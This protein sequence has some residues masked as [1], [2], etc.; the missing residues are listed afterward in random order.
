MVCS[1]SGG[2]NEDPCSSE[3]TG[4][5]DKF[6]ITEEHE[7]NHIKIMSAVPKKMGG[8]INS[9]NACSMGNKEK[10]EAIVKLENFDTERRGITECCSGSL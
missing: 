5:I 2:K 6:E 8:E 1:V 10:M 7:K 3:A 4:V 9:P